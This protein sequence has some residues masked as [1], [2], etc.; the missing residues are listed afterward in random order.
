ML[1]VVGK[2]GFVVPADVMRIKLLDLIEGVYVAWPLVVRPPLPTQH[3]CET[4]ALQHTCH[5]T[6]R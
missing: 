1:D 2:A 6:A 3:R 4:P 5:I